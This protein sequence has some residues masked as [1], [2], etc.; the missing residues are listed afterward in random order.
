[1]TIISPEMYSTCFLKKKAISC[2]GEIVGDSP[3][4]MALQAAFTTNSRGINNLSNIKIPVCTR[5][6][7]NPLRLFEP[8]C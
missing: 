8:V 6:S 4:E 3:E 1:M 2:A 7:L 5:I